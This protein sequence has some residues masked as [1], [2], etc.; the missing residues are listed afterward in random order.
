MKTLKGTQR[1]GD[2]VINKK[3]FL[4]NQS[5][6]KILQ[7]ETITISLYL[8][9]FFS[10]RLFLTIMALILI[11]SENIETKKVINTKH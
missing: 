8:K 1:F 9:N 3:L 10:P 7:E 4:E 5:H 2:G 6:R 11:F